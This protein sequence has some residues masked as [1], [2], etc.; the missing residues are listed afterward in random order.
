M[1][2]PFIYLQ[3]APQGDISVS[4][5]S[6]LNKYLPRP[7]FN[8]DNSWVVNS[9]NGDLSLN[10]QPV[11]NLFYELSLNKISLNRN[12][13][14]FS[15]KAELASYLE[16]SDFLTKLGLS[17]TEIDN[18]LGYI[19][20]ELQSAKDTK[21]YYLTIL[22]RPSTEEISSLNIKPEPKESGIL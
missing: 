17:Q 16:N 3:N 13:Q 21:F 22:N 18:S 9:Q 1:A 11:S 12:G 15:S 14:N 20:P 5:N 7:D 6:S 4:V 10:S 8:K 19:L 2:S